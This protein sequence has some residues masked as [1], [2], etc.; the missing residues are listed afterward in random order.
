LLILTLTTAT[1]AVR[2]IGAGIQKAIEFIEV[3]TPN[4]TSVNQEC[5]DLSKIT[6]SC[7][8]IMINDP[9]YT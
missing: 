9:I 3:K 2:V 4:R 5:K 6:E 1:C 8:I 7:N